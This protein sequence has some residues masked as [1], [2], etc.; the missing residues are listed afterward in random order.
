MDKETKRFVAER[1]LQVEQKLKTR[2]RHEIDALARIIAKTVKELATKEEL[3]S[4]QEQV[5][6]LKRST[7]RR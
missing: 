4:L 3:L 2:L 5:H 6:D 7:E 1:C